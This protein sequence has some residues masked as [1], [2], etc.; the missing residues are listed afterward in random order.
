MDVV[1]DPPRTDAVDMYRVAG[2]RI[3]WRFLLCDWKGV[4][5]QLTAG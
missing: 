5:D 1:A 4:L 3:V 2:G